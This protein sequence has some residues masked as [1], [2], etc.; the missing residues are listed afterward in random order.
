[1]FSVEQ[2]LLLNLKLD[3]IIKDGDHMIFKT[4]FNN[5]IFSINR[6]DSS[7]STEYGNRYIID[8]EIYNNLGTMITRVRMNEIGVLC[9]LDN[10]NVFLNNYDYQQAY[11]TLISAFGIGQTV[12][13]NFNIKMT[14]TDSSFRLNEYVNIPAE[15]NDIY[16]NEIREISI[17]IIENS[18]MNRS[19]QVMA[20]FLLSDHEFSDLMYAYFF[21]SL[22]DIDF[23]EREE[24]ILDNI[25]QTFLGCQM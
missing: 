15:I 17:E 10:M 21:V 8:T 11:N 12:L 4:P 22:I 18:P 5:Y 20:K 16:N 25:M 3:N 23:N 19:S 6:Y 24:C 1:M 2:N 7:V 9:L 14:R 13:T